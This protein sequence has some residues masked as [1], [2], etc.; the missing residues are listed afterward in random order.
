MDMYAYMHLSMT[1]SV[2][3]HNLLAP[4]LR[5]SALS[6]LLILSGL[7][8]LALVT[9]RTTFP[10]SPGFQKPKNTKAVKHVIK[11]LSTKGPKENL[12]VFSGFRT[13]RKTY[14]TS[15]REPTLIEV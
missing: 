4:K 3:A 8:C 7:V 5:I 10:F 14:I 2:R 11:E 12:E 1:Y 13:R 6:L 9:S 15:T